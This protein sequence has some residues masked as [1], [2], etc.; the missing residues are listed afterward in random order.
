MFVVTSLLAGCAV[1]PDYSPPELSTPRHFHG[2]LSLGKQETLDNAKL[3]AWWERFGDEQLSRYITIALEQNLDLSQATARVTQAQAGLGMANAALLPSGN[4]SG[5]AAR[6]YQSV[7]T[8]LGQVL[9]SSP[10]F[11]RYGNRYEANLSA[12]WELDLFGGLRRD[13]EAA[14]AEYQATT[15]GV[16]ATGLAVTAQTAN[17]YITIRALQTRLNIARRQV[18]TQQETLDL[19]NLLYNSGL[20]AERQVQ[21]ARASLTQAQAYVPALEAGLETAMNALDVILGTPPGTHRAELAT[22]VPI[23]STPTITEMGTPGELLS[24]RPDLIIAERHL[25]A[26]NAKIGAAMAEYYPKFSLSGLI[27]S[28]T[29]VESNLFTSDANQAAG[30]FGLR[31]RLFDFARINAQIEQAKG[32]EAEVLAAYRLAVLRATEDVENAFTTLVKREEQTTVLTQGVEALTRARSASFAAYQKGTASMLELLQV[33]EHLL[34][35]SDRQA[36]AQA[37]S[38]TAAVAAFKALG[39]G[40]QA[41]MEHL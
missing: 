30:V 1:G 4:I 13:R 33:D 15:A 23:P 28:A 34:Q 10:G 38:A 25:A 5:Q 27:G 14:L 16:A 26:S 32:R 9:N 22:L 37:E 19:L 20:A 12:S 24:R 7:E 35:A 2:Q 8:P 39:G 29:S 11:D 18:A 21:Q 40:W 3:Q 41:E 36:L 31:W 17:I 6:A